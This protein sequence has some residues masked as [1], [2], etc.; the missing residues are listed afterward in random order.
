ML[1]WKQWLWAEIAAVWRAVAAF[2]WNR[3]RYSIAAAVAATYMVSRAGLE[4]ATL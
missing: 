3:G 1:L 4:P 2:V